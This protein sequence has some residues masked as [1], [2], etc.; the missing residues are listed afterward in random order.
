MTT[1]LPSGSGTSNTLARRW[2]YYEAM[3]FL[4]PH[5]I[6]RPTSS[7]VPTPPEDTCH[8]T[9]YAPQ[10]SFSPS[11]EVQ[12]NA[13][14]P[15]ATASTVCDDLITVTPFV[16]TPKPSVTRKRNRDN[17]DDMDM[18]FLEEIK[19]LREQ[20]SVQNDPDRQYLLSLLPMMKKLSPSN[21]MDIK[22]EIYELFRKKLFPPALANQYGYWTEQ[23]QSGRPASSASSESFN[24]SE[25]SS[26][27]YC[28]I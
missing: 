4:H 15:E 20:A 14:P 22:I 9:D 1:K 23:N 7:N 17:I 19:Q 28:V 27:D 16:P 21:N 10:T 8:E 3:E 12:N 26:S 24:Y 2:V 25:H 13:S 18:R 5:V 11:I 6:S